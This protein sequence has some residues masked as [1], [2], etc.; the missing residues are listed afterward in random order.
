MVKEGRPCLETLTLLA[1]VRSALDSTGEVILEAQLL[2]GWANA[3][4]RC[5]EVKG[6]IS[7]VKLLRG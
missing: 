7:A 1:G 3:D 2:E 5:H 6:I 4:E